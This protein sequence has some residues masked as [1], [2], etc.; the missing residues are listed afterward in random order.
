V[1]RDKSV[2]DEALEE[3]VRQ[4]AVEAVPIMPLLNGTFM[5]RPGRPEKSITTRDSASS[6]GT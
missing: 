5:C 1:Q 3:L 4:L 2:V 6:S